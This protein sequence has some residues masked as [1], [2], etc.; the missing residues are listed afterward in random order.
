MLLGSLYYIK[1]ISLVYFSGKV[2]F[3]THFLCSVWLFV[4]S[5]IVFHPRGFSPTVL[6]SEVTVFETLLCAK[7]AIAEI[8]LSLARAS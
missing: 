7:E 6:A 2:P 1:N 8:A 3:L 5:I 4:P